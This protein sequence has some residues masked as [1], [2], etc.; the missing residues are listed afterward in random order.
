MR[1]SAEE[2]RPLV[3]SSGR[4]LC[5]RW[6]GGNNH[7]RGWPAAGG[8]SAQGYARSTSAIPAAAGVALRRGLERI[9]TLVV[10]CTGG[11]NRTAE[12]LMA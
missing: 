10:G 8:S 2:G 4:L 1:S 6:R 12:R 3:S 9:A 7:R 5:G 11:G